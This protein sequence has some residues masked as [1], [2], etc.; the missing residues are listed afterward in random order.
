MCITLRWLPLALPTSDP[1]PCV[2]IYLSTLRV[3]D[4]GSVR[5]VIC[6]Q[7]LGMTVASRASSVCNWCSF[8]RCPR[9]EQHRFTPYL[10]FYLLAFVYILYMR[11]AYFEPDIRSKRVLNTY[12]SRMERPGGVCLSVHW[13]FLADLQSVETMMTA[14]ERRR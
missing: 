1:I 2:H 14:T 3:N 11:S 8:E 9:S 10:I 4:C 7:W 6:T 5:V 13:S 12:T